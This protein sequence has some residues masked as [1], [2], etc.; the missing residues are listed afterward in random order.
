MARK[1]L[2]DIA[3]QIGRITRSQA[4]ERHLSLLAKARDKAKEYKANILRAQ[5]V[6][7]RFNDKTLKMEYVTK[8]GRTISAGQVEGTRMP[9]KVYRDGKSFTNG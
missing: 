3:A 9:T 4:S 1:S 6:T 5:K 2:N 7:P 8:E